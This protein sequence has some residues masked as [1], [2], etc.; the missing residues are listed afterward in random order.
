ML[1][2]P[3]GSGFIWH[4]TL[5]ASKTPAHTAPDVVTV[6]E[7]GSDDVYVIV[8]V[9][10]TALLLE[11]STWTLPNADTTPRSREKLVGFATIEA[12]VFVSVVVDECPPPHDASTA[13][14]PIRS[15]NRVTRKRRMYPPR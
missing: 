5:F 7:F 15:K 4:T 12:G 6:T 13:V 2:G 3:G 9:G 8:G 1:T 14:A 10:E 11:F